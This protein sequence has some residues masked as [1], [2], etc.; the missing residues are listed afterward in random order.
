[1]GE[2]YSTRCVVCFFVALVLKCKQ[3]EKC[4]GMVVMRDIDVWSLCE[5]H[6]VPFYGKAHIA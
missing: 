2:A 4:D 3:D 5:H 1:L 6:M